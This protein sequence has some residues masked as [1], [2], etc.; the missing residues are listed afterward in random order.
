MRPIFSNNADNM[1]SPEFSLS[2]STRETLNFLILVIIT[3]GNI[4]FGFPPTFYE[5]LNRNIG[6]LRVFIDAPP[7]FLWTARISVIFLFIVSFQVRF[8]RG[9]PPMIE[10]MYGRFSLLVSISLSLTPTSIG[11][12]VVLLLEKSSLFLFPPFTYS[13]NYPLLIR[14]SMEFFKCIQLSILLL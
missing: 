10:E 3:N 13:N 1:I 12:E 14:P 9:F 11:F 4:L 7:S 5:S 6:Q 2:T 8:A